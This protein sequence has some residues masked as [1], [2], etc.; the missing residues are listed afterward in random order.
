MGRWWE[1]GQ[2]LPR[3]EVDAHGL[4]LS[5]ELLLPCLV[6]IVWPY[7]RPPLPQECLKRRL[8]LD[9]LRSLFSLARAGYAAVPEAGPVDIPG[10]GAQL[11]GLTTSVDPGRSLLSLF[12][13]IPALHESVLCDDLD[14]LAGVLCSD[15]AQG[16][17]TELYCAIL[18]YTVLCCVL[19][20]YTVLYCTI[21]YYIVLCCTTKYYTVLYCTIL[22]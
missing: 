7:R 3:S 6:E 4:N 16:T 15:L 14:D 21:L 1:P 10:S 13:R 8:A 19:V 2:G 22:Y 11:P 5:T 20:Y 12:P 18:H 17:A 9:L